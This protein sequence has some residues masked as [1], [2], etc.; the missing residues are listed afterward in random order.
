[1]QE[2]DHFTQANNSLFFFALGNEQSFS[3]SKSAL[4]AINDPMK[5]FQLFDVVEYVRFIMANTDWAQDYPP[6]TLLET[7]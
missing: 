5:V 4:L 1:M 7:Q 3:S 6:T 2:H